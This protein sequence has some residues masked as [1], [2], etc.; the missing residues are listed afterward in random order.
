MGLA[1]VNIYMRVIYMRVY[2]E[3]GVHGTEDLNLQGLCTVECIIAWISNGIV[4]SSCITVW[5]QHQSKP[6]DITVCVAGRRNLSAVFP[7]QI[8]QLLHK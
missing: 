4:Y 1:D 2:T 3:Y 8:T 6:R 7:T 5:Y